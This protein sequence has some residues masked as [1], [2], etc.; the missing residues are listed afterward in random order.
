MTSNSSDVSLTD[1][2][3]AAFGDHKII[4]SMLPAAVGLVSYFIV[5]TFGNLN[6]A[7]A[8]FLN[9]KLRGT[10]N[11]LIAMASFFDSI[12]MSAHVF[13][14]YFVVTGINIIPL[15]QCYRIMLLPIAG[16]MCGEMVI[17]LI[18]VDRL[19]SLLCPTT[20]R[21]LNKL[22]YLLF[23]LSLCVALSAWYLYL[24][25]LNQLENPNQ[26]VLCLIIEGVHG[27]L[28]EWF[29]EIAMILN[30]AT[31]ACYFVLFVC[32]R[33]KG[34]DAGSKKIFKSLMWIVGV[35]CGTWFVTAAYANLVTRYFNL[36]PPD[37]AVSLS[38]SGLF[39]NAGCSCNF[40]ILYKCSAE[41]R[42]QS[43]KQLRWLTCG[44]I[45]FSD[46][47]VAPL[48]RPTRWN[49]EMQSSTS[50]YGDSDSVA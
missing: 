26:L 18:G 35:V 41:Y 46:V 45:K 38:Y 16:L 39:I 8:P 47:D 44:L 14:F 37:Q 22:P 11:Y 4:V 40:F 33:K 23:L 30:F 15:H 25:Y 20:H 19:F 31:V 10:C 27:Y 50:K 5:G 7:V 9:P 17:L 32:V 21:T 1:P 43:K 13:L 28:I 24:G 12:H 49:T 2:I 6:I 34:S 36:S 29:T 48:S 42:K 3:S